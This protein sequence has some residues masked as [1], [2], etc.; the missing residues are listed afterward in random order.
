MSEKNDF[1]VKGLIKK[2]YQL[3]PFKK[4]LFV[5]LKKIYIPPRRIYQHLHFNGIY[6]VEID[7][8]RFFEIQH[9]GYLIENEIFW[10]G[11][12]NGWEKYSM[13]IWMALCVDATT[14]LDIGS[15]TGIYSL[16]AKTINPDSTVYA[17]EPVERV[18]RKL[19]LNVKL[20]DF[21]IKCFQ[22]AAS[23]KIGKAVIYDSDS[24][25]TLSVAVNKNI[26][27]TPENTFEVE[28]DTITL[29]QF[30]VDHNIAK[31]D[32]IKID[33]ET[34]EVEVLKGFANHLRK[35]QPTMIIEILNSEVAS[36]IEKIIADLDYSYFN[37]DEN[38]GI[39]EV[40]SL[41]KSDYYNFLICKDKV[42][43][44]I[45]SQFLL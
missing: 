43:E 8:N 45:R 34:H 36:G 17:L 40:K 42:A 26:S 4:E 15:N 14:I 19:E 9:Y 29:D 22:K 39:R 30:V 33:V 24:D 1:S 41:G 25:H 28:I 11:I 7:S 13:R 37:I 12:F 44:R 3:V 6:K 18:F 10:N 32:L 21:N 5:L 2:V 35:F 20:N 23:D 16:V 38:S 27:E 31:V